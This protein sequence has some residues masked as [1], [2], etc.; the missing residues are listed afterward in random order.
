[1]TTAIERAQFA[2]ESHQATLMAETEQ[3]R[4]DLLSS[5]SHDLRTP[6]ASI[7]GSASAL[8]IQPELTSQSR[9]LAAT[10]REESNRLERLVR[11]LLDMT[12][13]QG[14]VDLRLDWYT[15]DEVVESAVSRTA[16]LF[17][18]P[19]VVE[20][21][22]VPIMVQIDGLLFEQ[23]LVNL[24]ENA[25]RHAGRDTVVTIRLSQ[26][27]GFAVIGFEDQ[28]PG[29]SPDRQ[30]HVFDRFESGGAVGSGLGLAIAKAAVEAHG[31]TIDLVP[32]AV[33]A[34]FEIRVPLGK[35]VVDV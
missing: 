6:L 11:N 30:P 15:L 28:G 7:T 23:V 17:D 1:L 3:L 10:I 27:E 16:D 5:V 2:K 25:S 33:G 26:A 21:P 19:V 9:E 35:E 32:S 34:K 13:I 31:G 12:R 4:S 14:K 20:T 22:P 24:L 29:I 18:L 8:E